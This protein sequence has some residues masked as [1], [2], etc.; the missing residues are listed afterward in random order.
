MEPRLV[1]CSHAVAPGLPCAPVEPREVRLCR[2]LRSEGHPHPGS[3]GDDDG[4]VA[5]VEVV[6]EP[7]TRPEPLGEAIR[8]GPFVSVPP[9]RPLLGLNSADVCALTPCPLGSAYG[10]M[11]ETATVSRDETDKTA[12][13][14]TAT[15]GKS[16]PERAERDWGS[17][18]RGSGTGAFAESGS[19]FGI[20]PGGPGPGHV[21]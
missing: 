16:H 1:I 4:E 8:L 20:S 7:A 5:A 21:R 12:T 11:G 9:V 15:Y 3:V 18:T 19:I 2:G 13:A 10:V 17:R 6:A 14:S